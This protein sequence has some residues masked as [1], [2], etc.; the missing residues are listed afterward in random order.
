MSDDIYV[1][2]RDRVLEALRSAVPDL[3]ASIADKIEV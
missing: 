2:M 1:R 3:P